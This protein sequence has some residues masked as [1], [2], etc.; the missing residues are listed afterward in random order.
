MKIKSLNI[1]S[2]GKFSNKKIEFKDGLNI[3]YGGNEAGKSTLMS[4]I[5]SMLFG[6]TAPKVSDVSRNERKRYMPWGG[7]VLSG[8]M[9]IET[10]G[11]KTVRIL[12]TSGKS[13]A[14]DT[15]ECFDVTNS[16][17]YDFVPEAEVGI[18]EEAFLKTFY[19][20]QL[21]TMI[22]GENEEL[23]QKLINLTHNASEDVN[24]KSAVDKLRERMKDIKSRS[25]NA[26]VNV[27]TQK[28]EELNSELSMVQEKRMESF[29]VVEKEKEL[30][31][32]SEKLRT[33]TENLLKM[34]ESAALTEKYNALIK[35]K[36]DADTVKCSM[37]KTESEIKAA[38]EFIAQNALFE[39]KPSDIIYSAKEK[40]EDLEDDLNKEKNKKP[41]IPLI[42]IIA[43]AALV[44]ALSYVLFKKTAL[45]LISFACI[46][47]GAAAAFIFFAG[48]RKAKI[49]DT[50]A[51]L[52]KKREFNAGIENELARFGVS[53]VKEYN[54]KADAFKEA[55]LKSAALSEKTEDLKIK[56]TELNNT[57]NSIHI[58]EGFTPSEIPY[59]L[60]QID[61]MIDEKREL[62]EKTVA[63]YARLE[64]IIS[65]G[66]D[67]ERTPDIILAER[68]DLSSQLDEAN[69]EYDALS[70]A[71][72][73]LEE[74]Y[75]QMSSDYTPAINKKASEI[76]SKITNGKYEELYLDKEY[77][78]KLLYDG[79]K[80]LGYF[81]S[82]TCDAVYFCVRLAVTDTLFGTD[83]PIFIDDGFT[84]YDDERE[85]NAMSELSI[86]AQNGQQIIIFTCRKPGN[87]GL[88]D[89]VNI[90]NL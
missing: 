7:K 49:K 6:F 73:C 13:Q 79:T 81:S 29:E 36:Q 43:A 88:K 19:I 42:I 52:L 4:Y 31:K 68:A 3:V 40:T 48:K 86:R 57:I 78:V 44:S 28:I 24:I 53:S 33:E 34:K 85:A 87:L 71:A 70:L 50:E 39:T 9:D 21:G 35:A 76:L 20:K 56:L 89:D 37:D 84:Q 2:Y 62:L 32:A 25:S 10:D 72:E 90:I 30:L 65:A 5:K 61:M 1:I 17:K 41:L 46:S 47:A 75:S 69:A 51:E 60:P 54:E 8:E 22:S 63:E 82:G 18:G 55:K 64:G 27:L 67:N 11:G 12:R 80:T 15:L 14:F 59:S 83:K 74:V 66:S 16:E 26:E 77:S 45:S 58:P 38:E 23:A